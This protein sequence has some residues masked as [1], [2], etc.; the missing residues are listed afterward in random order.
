MC[1]HCREHNNGKLI[2]TALIGAAIGTVIGFLTAPASGEETRKKVKDKAEDVAKNKDKLIEDFKDNVA[3]Q[4]EI[5]KKDLASKT[6]MAKAEAEKA[7]NPILDKIEEFA[8]GLDQEE[9]PTKPTK[10]N[11]S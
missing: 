2:V 1:K 8:D 9:T 5:L 4:A 11:K 6:D 7:L 3:E 10:S